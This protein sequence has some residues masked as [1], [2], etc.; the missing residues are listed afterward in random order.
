MF[1]IALV[2]FLLAAFGIG[3]VLANYLPI[4]IGVATLI[5]GLVL[6][7]MGQR[8]R[9]CTISG[10]RD[11]YLVKDTYRLKGL[12]GIVVGGIIG[13]N[14][15][16]WISGA[17]ELPGVPDFPMLAEGL[18]VEPMVLLPISI[19]GAFGMAFFS[20]MAEGCPFR[21]H[22]MAG[23]GYLSGMLYLLGLVLGIIF[24]DI[25]IIPYLQLL[26]LIG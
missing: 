2:I 12:I 7:Y 8:S 14:V 11:F 3:W 6:G 17:S 25:V 22:V 26:T 23:E 10:L 9:F 20:V 5:V 21:Q 16:K 4:N 24:F 1:L 13:F 15:V 18:K 19:V